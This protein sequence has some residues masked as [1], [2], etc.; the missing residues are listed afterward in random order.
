LIKHVHVDDEGS[1]WV[2]TSHQKNKTRPVFKSTNGKDYQL[3]FD[4]SPHLGDKLVAWWSGISDAG[5]LFY[6]HDKYGGLLILNAQGVKQELYLK[7]PQDFEEKMDCS[8]FRVDNKNNLWRMY[9]QDFAIYNKQL[10]K[11][12]SQPLSK[13]ANA[14]S[15]CPTYFHQGFEINF[16]WTD[17]KGRQWF[18]GGDSNL[19]LYD[20]AKDELTFFGKTIVDQIGGRGGDIHSLVG[21]GKGNFYGA[22]R[23]GVFKIS[24][25][26]DYFQSYVVNTKNEKH[27]IYNPL[28]KQVMDYVGEEHLTNSIISSICEDQRGDL[29]FIDYRFIFKLN[30]ATDEVAILPLFS[31]ISKLNLNFTNNH[32]VLSGWSSVLN[33]DDQFNVTPS[34]YSPSKL[35]KVFEQKNGAIW[36]TG[37]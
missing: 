14:H 26:Q 3:A 23:G 4:L 7:D 22:K 20:Q 17:Y 29:F 32:K 5:G 9:Q 16:I 8:V 6:F 15:D 24:E 21:D 12:I 11:F 19:Y 25:K 18:G 37:Y 10:G 33:I 1:I 34:A 28:P 30:T 27:P 2:F 35:E 36:F 13:K 31:P